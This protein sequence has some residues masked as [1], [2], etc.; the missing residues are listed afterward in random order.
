MA[1]KK[2]NLKQVFNAWIKH[3][4]KEKEAADLRWKL[5]QICNECEEDTALIEHEGTVYRITVTKPY[6]NNWDKQ[7]EIKPVAAVT[8]IKSL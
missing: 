8:E 3:K 6:R 5:R 7:F 1:T 4:K 2:T